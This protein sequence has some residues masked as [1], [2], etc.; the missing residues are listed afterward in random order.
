[1]D[2]LLDRGEGVIAQVLRLVIA[3]EQAN[4]QTAEQIAR[5]LQIDFAALPT[6]FERS[7][8]LL[9]AFDLTL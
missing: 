5:L 6:L 2:A 4:W 1:M 3:Y 9:E 8:D 7:L